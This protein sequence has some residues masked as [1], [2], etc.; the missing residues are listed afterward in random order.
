MRPKTFRVFKNA[1]FDSYPLRWL[2]DDKD[3]VAY[4]QNETAVTL[5]K[6]DQILQLPGN[7]NL[8][9]NG[10]DEKSRP[11]MGIYENCPYT[12]K[13]SV[14]DMSGLESPGKFGHEEKLLEGGEEIMTEKLEFGEM[15]DE[16]LDGKL[17]KDI[18]QK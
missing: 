11:S 1:E 17:M 5:E 9:V 7:N 4:N 2:P 15:N 12:P 13:K 16:G 3:Q 8:D 10:E 14:S 6:Y 18:L